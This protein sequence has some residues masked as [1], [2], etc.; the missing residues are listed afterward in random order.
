MDR[1]KIVYVMGPSGAGKTRLI[2]YARRKIDGSLPLVFAHRYI[3]RPLGTDGENYVALTDPEFAL[4]KAYGLF[5]CDWQ[6]YQWTYGIG[7]ELVDWLNAGLSVVID[8]SRAHFAAQRLE[9][10]PIVPV[11]VGARRELLRERLTARE[12]EDAQ[13]IEE[14]LERAERYPPTDLALINIDNSAAIEAAGES[15]VRI[16]AD[17]APR[18]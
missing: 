3:T 8:G 17:A 9:L 10:A 11:F 12:R 2:D 7:I 14:R 1:P 5:A 13:A 15:F 6:A 4:R 16:L 18:K